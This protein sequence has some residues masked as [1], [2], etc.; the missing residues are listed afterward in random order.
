MTAAF[1]C[2]ALRVVFPSIHFTLFLAINWHF[3]FPL[4]SCIVCTIFCRLLKLACLLI[5]LLLSQLV[6]LQFGYY[7]AQSELSATNPGGI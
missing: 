4:L 3:G 2:L 7:P 6:V 1:A 5:L